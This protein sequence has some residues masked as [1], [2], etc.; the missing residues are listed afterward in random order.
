MET[1]IGTV[2]F[3]KT[4]TALTSESQM[5][6]RNIA[7]TLLANRNLMVNIYGH[8]SDDHTSFDDI[9]TARGLADRIK[10]QLVFDLQISSE[11]IQT[12]GLSPRNKTTDPWVE[13]T[14]RRPDALLTWYE[15]DVK[16]QPPS[17]RPNWL[18]PHRNY[19]LYRSYRITTGK[20]SRAHILYP[21]N[22]TLKMD[23]EAMVIIQTPQSDQRESSFLGNIKLQNG[24]LED[25]LED[26]ICQDDSIAESTAALTVRTT[27]INKTSVDEKM[28]DLIVA[29]TGD[30]EESVADTIAGHKTTTDKSKK[31]DDKIT[32]LAGLG[33][34]I[35]EPTGVSLKKWIVETKAI[36]F[37]IGW[38]FPGQSIHFA[39]DYQTHFPEWFNNNKLYPYLEIGGRLKMRQETED[40]PIR[41][42]MRF[43]IGIEY[44]HGHFGIYS[45]ICPAMDITP[46]TRLALEGGIGAHYY[47]TN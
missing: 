14:I 44:I 19:Y 34:I 33:I 38:S 18:I 26:A 43:G 9:A 41:L 16:V 46:E 47:F 39:V 29:Y 30:S 7:D 17:L 37:Q 2:H 5:V 13:I 11:R 31:H 40:G 27:E 21:N 24:M 36:D 15:N 1:S 3:E 20:N 23:E 12:L 8:V 35:G 45:E 25:M 28:T 22:S 32:A 6:L 10:H 42:G 4:D